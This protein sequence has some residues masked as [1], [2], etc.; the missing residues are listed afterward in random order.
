MLYSYAFS[1]FLVI[2]LYHGDVRDETSKVMYFLC[3]LCYLGAMLASNK[4]LQYVNYP[5]QVCFHLDY[6]FFFFFNLIVINCRSTKKKLTL[7]SKNKGC[8]NIGGEY[9]VQHPKVGEIGF[10]SDSCL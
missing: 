3:A 6:Y 8:V 10:L 2:K 7:S 5:T 9:E 4:A 1:I